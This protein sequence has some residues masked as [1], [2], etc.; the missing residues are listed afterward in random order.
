MLTLL[1]LHLHAVAVAAAALLPGLLL[2]L[3]PVSALLLVR[4]AVVDGVT[5]VYE[6]GLWGAELLPMPIHRSILNLVSSISFC[7]VGTAGEISL[8]LHRLTVAYRLHI[9]A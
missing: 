5:T 4:V 8:P 9:P 2:P 6:A 1:L 3:L 7:R